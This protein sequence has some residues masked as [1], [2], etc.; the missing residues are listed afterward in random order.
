MIKFVYMLLFLNY[1]F[2]MISSHECYNVQYQIDYSIRRGSMQD[3]SGVKKLYQRVASIP[4]SLSRNK[5]EITDVYIQK[6]I[7]AGM[8]GL[9]L[10]VEYQGEII[11]SMIKC[12][13]DLTNF[14]HVFTD[15]SI[16]ID[17]EFQ[18][19][20]IGS[21]LI[22]TFLQEVQNNY[23]DILRVEIIARESNPAIKLY[24]RLGFIEEGRF[25]RI[26]KDAYG[27]LEA[28]IPMVWF[29]P[30]YKP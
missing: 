16:L 7:S 25:E 11:G 14:T 24:K 18:G 23:T 1:S 13:I 30:N 6:I 8:Q 20:G 17:L 28:G 29:N 21:E 10:V 2:L 26:I 27:N 5:D 15:G 19:K 9:F 3:E 12:R 22:S 4:G